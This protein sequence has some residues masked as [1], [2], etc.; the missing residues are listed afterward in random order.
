[1]SGF[2]YA[3]MEMWKKFSSN[4]I[5]GAERP[6]GYKLSISTCRE[7]HH[8]VNRRYSKARLR[9]VF[10]VKSL[11]YFIFKL[12]I[13]S[14]GLERFKKYEVKPP[15]LCLTVWVVGEDISLVGKCPHEH[16]EPLLTLRLILLPLGGI[17]SGKMKFLRLHHQGS[18]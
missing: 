6:S 2:L 5:S 9:Q 4:S 7:K 3:R 18:R 10:F 15:R 1:M 14:A 13:Y 16:M 8:V 12:N 17:R 11:S